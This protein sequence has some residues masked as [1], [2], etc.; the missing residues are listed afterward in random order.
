[1]E[2]VQQP[3]AQSLNPYKEGNLAQDP[4][5]KSLYFMTNKPLIV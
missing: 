4:N 2:F 1:V 5:E 3:A